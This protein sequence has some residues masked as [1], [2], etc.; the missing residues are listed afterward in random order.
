MKIM[1]IVVRD[2]KGNC[3]DQF[4]LTNE[5]MFDIMLKNIRKCYG[6]VIWHHTGSFGERPA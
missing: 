2:F 3:L 4:L 6:E 1:T 5:K